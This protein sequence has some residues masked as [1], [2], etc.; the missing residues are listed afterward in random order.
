MSSS[1]TTWE[2][3]WSGITKGQMKTFEYDEHI[4][5]LDCGNTFKI[6][7]TLNFIFSLCTIFVL[8]YNKA[9]KILSQRNNH[10]QTNQEVA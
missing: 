7:R 5:N 1:V 6:Q 9:V 2:N 10:F 8:F 3:P 4:S